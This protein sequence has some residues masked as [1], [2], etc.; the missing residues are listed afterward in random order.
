MNRT[1][2][3]LKGL[4]VVLFL[5]GSTGCDALEGVNPFNNEKEVT[6]VV[7]A[8]DTE[9]SA[10]TVDGIEYTVT[11]GTEFEGVDGLSA[12]ST[13]DEVEVEYKET[14]SGREAEEVELAGS[15]DD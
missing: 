3:I 8:I 13:G 15:D 5:F 12:L 7:E 11:D 9:N 1:R 4:L 10:L 6:G 14:D 2:T